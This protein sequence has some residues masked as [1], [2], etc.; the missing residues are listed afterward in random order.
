MLGVIG[1][2]NEATP[3]SP[4]PALLSPPSSPLSPDAPLA[5][6]LWGRRNGAGREG[7]ELRW[8]RQV[9]IHRYPLRPHRDP[10]GP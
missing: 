9:G 3:T 6:A 8:G 10:K 2:A 1:Y 5:D 4:S 7:V